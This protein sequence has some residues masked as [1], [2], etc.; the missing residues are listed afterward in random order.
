MLNI[1]IHRIKYFIKQARKEVDI[2][3][4]VIFKF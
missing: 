3:I 1:L 2:E 4:P